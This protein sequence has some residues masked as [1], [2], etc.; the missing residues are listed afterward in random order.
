MQMKELEY[1]KRRLEKLKTQ[2]LFIREKLGLIKDEKKDLQKALRYRNDLFHSIPD[3][4]ILIQDE[5]VIDANHVALNHL[6]YK[7]EEMIGREI[8]AFVH[9]AMRSFA[10]RSA[11]LSWQEPR[12]T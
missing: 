2:N 3:A 6:G 5:K 4:L 11:A 7:A 1:W 12:P 8:L 9:P 10:N